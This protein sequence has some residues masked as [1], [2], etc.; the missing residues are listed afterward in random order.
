M[1]VPLGGRLG[2]AAQLCQ[3]PQNGLFF[4]DSTY[5]ESSAV[6]DWAI[7]YVTVIM[8]L[9]PVLLKISAELETFLVGYG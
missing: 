6:M 9:S 7:L 2:V 8:A 5:G 3:V 1:G 4:F